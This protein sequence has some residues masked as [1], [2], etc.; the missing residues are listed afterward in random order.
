MFEP[1]H[2]LLSQSYVMSIG[3]LCVARIAKCDLDW[4]KSRQK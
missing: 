1:T 3:F 4:N 2:D